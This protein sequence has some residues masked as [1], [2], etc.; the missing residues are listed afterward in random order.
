MPYGKIAAYG[1][2]PTTASFYFGVYFSLLTAN[3]QKD[4]NYSGARIA[5]VEGESLVVCTMRPAWFHD[6]LQCTMETTYEADRAILDANTETNKFMDWLKNGDWGMRDLFGQ[7][8][9]YANLAPSTPYWNASYGIPY[10]PPVQ[11]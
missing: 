3:S 1:T 7:G 9:S 8:C 6:A 10:Q 2:I 4:F 11:F 5:L